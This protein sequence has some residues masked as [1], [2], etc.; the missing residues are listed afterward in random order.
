MD[1]NI[2]ITKDLI[3]S[4]DPLLRAKSGQAIYI[5]DTNIKD[6]FFGSYAATKAAQ[7][8]LFEIW[9]AEM[10]ASGFRVAGFEAKP[11]PTATRARF[12]PGE[13]KDAL[14]QCKAEAERLIQSLVM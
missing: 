12:F 11:M 6:K 3:E 7:E 13:D 14:T 5:R 2:G 9:G 10:A 4:V 1:T 8:K